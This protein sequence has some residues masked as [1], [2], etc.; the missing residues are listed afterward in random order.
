MQ[1]FSNVDLG[2]IKIHKK[3]IADIVNGTIKD[4]KSIALIPENIVSFTTELLGI[5][6]YPGIFVKIDK[7]NRISVEVRIRVKTG[8]NIPE[9]A[10][11]VQET[12]RTALEKSVDIDLKVVNVIIQGIE[13]GGQ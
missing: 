13:R 8:T 2:T 1:R 3:A 7:N 11:Q 9:L 10:V 4:I 12:I 5:T 6:H